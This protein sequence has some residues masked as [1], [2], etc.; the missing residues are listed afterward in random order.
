MPHRVELLAGYRF[1]YL[2][3]GNFR[4]KGPWPGSLWEQDTGGRGDEGLVSVLQTGV[5][6]DNRDNEPAPTKGYW[7]EATIR[8]AHKFWGSDYNYVGCNITARTYA[9][10]V[11]SLVWANRVVLDGMAGNAHIE[12]LGRP[13]GTARY[14]MYGE[15]RAGR[16][17]RLTRF[18]GRLK[19]MEQSELRWTALSGPVFQVPID[20]TLVGFVDVGFVAQDWQHLD[21]LARPLVGTGGG[22]RI[23]VDKNFIVRTDV[24]VSALEDWSPSIYIDLGNTF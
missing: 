18:A 2:I 7:H 1:N 4:E 19:N 14:Y 13:G 10:L 20:L 21:E 16:G 11:P 9:S 12:E 23:A 22:L 15:Q 8:G 17:V 24:G 3:P 6:I 5:M